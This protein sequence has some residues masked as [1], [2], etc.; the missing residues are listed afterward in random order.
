VTLLL[1]IP[2]ALALGV[3]IYALPYLIVAIWNL[4]MTIDKRRD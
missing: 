4:V 2:V 1:I 3:L